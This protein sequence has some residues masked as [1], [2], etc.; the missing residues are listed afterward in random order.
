MET[1]KPP[2]SNR[3]LVID[4]EVGIT[5]VIEHAARALGFEVLSIHDPDQFE[6]GLTKI[7][8]NVIFLDIAMPGRDGMQLIGHLAS[9]RYGG[10]IVIMSG[11]GPLYPDE[12][13]LGQ[14]TRA[15]D[16]GNAV[17]AISEAG[18]YEAS[19]LAMAAIV[20][21]TPAA[22]ASG[23]LGPMTAEYGR[24]RIADLGSRAAQGLAASFPCRVGPT[25]RR[26]AFSRAC[27]WVP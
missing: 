16:S 22:R 1:E 12:C 8:P 15:R 5:S 9:N 4:D 11:S 24:G 26:A 21:E 10:Q 20:S 19:I 27:S 13:R 18:D 25:C 17:Q 7:R 2:N 14:G 3:L 23:G 6:K